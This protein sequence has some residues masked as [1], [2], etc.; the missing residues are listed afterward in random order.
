MRA[1]SEYVRNLS[2]AEDGALDGLDTV[3]R[4]LAP[5]V[6][7]AEGEEQMR[8]RD[9]LS[10]QLEAVAWWGDESSRERQEVLHRV[11]HAMTKL[12]QDL[13]GEI[14]NALADDLRRTPLDAG[15][16]T[17]PALHGLANMGSELGASAESVLDELAVADEEGNS[18]P[19]WTTRARV[20]LALSARHAGREVDASIVS[21]EGMVQA[22]SRESAHGNSAVIDWLQLGPGADSVVAVLGALGG[23]PDSEI[24]RSFESWCQDTSEAQR[25]SVAIAVLSLQRG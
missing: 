14:E 21:D 7:M 22:A 20:A 19:V 25:T 3:V 1:V 24:L 4:S 9:A 10:E 18:F 12:E 11:G 5:F 16:L 2:P 8:I 13:A 6:K 15:S 23:K 17:E